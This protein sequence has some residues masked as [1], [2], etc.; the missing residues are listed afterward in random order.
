MLYLMI[1]NLTC[2]LIILPYKSDF[3]LILLTYL[4]DHMALTIKIHQ[5]PTFFP[6]IYLFLGIIPI[7]MPK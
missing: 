1:K 2:P 4:K 5:T 6:L 7:S 3:I